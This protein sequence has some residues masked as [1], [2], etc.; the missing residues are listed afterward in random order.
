M[1]AAT[2][3]ALW[4]KGFVE[5]ISPPPI[6][7]HVFVQQILALV[8]QTPDFAQSDWTSWIGRV[9]AFAQLEGSRADAIFGF[10][11][12]QG[13]ICSDSG[14]L[15][16]G[17]E[18]ERRLSHRHYSE[19]LSVITSQPLFKVLF[20]RV[21]IGSV[22]PLSFTNGKDTPVILALGGRG[23]R[24]NH[25]DWKRKVA[26]VVPDAGSGRSRW[27]GSSVPLSATLCTAV[28]HLLQ[29]SEQPPTWSKRA[30]GRLDGL[31]KDLSP[32]CGEGSCIGRKG[33]AL[34]WW[35]FAGLA[36]NQTL[37][38]YLTPH[39]GLSLRADNLWISLPPETPH[40]RLAEIVEKV[41][42]ADG[43]PNWDLQHSANDLL[44]FGDLLPDHL[45]RELI[46]VRIADVPNAQKILQSPIKFIDS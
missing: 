23:W 1:H 17:P 21:E 19:L 41:R 46:L 38:Q 40:H 27:I 13:L 7:Y 29:S 14:R 35:T 2:L 34:E 42:H 32:L 8:L 12:E 39:L 28:K 9:P 43:E 16:L 30:I 20:G 18:A 6:P 3:M 25:I 36:T 33:N 4:S 22:H 10:A 45:L 37:I 5:D 31:R 15:H 44:K 26:H 11:L 24:L